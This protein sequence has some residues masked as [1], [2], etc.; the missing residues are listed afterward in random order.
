MQNII[1]D[2]IAVEV[3]QIGL[4]LI[5]RCHEAVPESGHVEKLLVHG[6]HVAHGAQVKETT[7][8]VD[9][10][11]QGHRREVGPCRLVNLEHLCQPVL[12]Q[13][14]EDHLLIRINLEHRQKQIKARS[15]AFLGLTLIYV[16]LFIRFQVRFDC[17]VLLDGVEVHAEQAAL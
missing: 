13:D 10:A 2:L 17:N 16:L 7:V 3:Y 12:L 4:C 5:L 9:A 8:A 6:I 15:R 14:F 1:I 11:T